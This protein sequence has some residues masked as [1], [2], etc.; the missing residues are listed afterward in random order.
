MYAEVPIMVEVCA[1]VMFCEDNDLAKP[2]SP[3]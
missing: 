2:K 1:E 3:S